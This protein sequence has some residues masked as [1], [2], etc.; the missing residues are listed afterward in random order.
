MLVELART[1][2]TNLKSELFCENPHD[3]V[4]GAKLSPANT[5]GRRIAPNKNSKQK[6]VAFILAELHV[7][8]TPCPNPTVARQRRSK[9]SVRTSR[10]QRRLVRI[11]HGVRSS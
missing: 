10:R 7:Q 9:A 5:S 4:L 11:R 2:R 3:V 6:S 8:F 1:N